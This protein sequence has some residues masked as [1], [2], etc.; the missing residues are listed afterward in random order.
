MNTVASA[1]MLAG[2]LVAVLAGLGAGDG[3]TDE[4]R[5]ARALEPL[6]AVRVTAEETLP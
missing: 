5:R 4:E 1:L 3:E 2:G 6:G